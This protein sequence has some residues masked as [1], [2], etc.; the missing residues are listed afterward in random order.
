MI[1]AL[2]EGLLP[3]LQGQDMTATKLSLQDHFSEAYATYDEWQPPPT[4]GQGAQLIAKMAPP[5]ASFCVDVKGVATA[6]IR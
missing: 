5:F 1:D 6:T 3:L 4:A 2:S